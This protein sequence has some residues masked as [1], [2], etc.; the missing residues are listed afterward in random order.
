MIFQN[1]KWFKLY[2]DKQAS[3]MT[4]KTNLICNW[5]YDSIYTYNLKI[6]KGYNIEISLIFSQ[7]ITRHI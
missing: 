1:K 2:F 7:Q 3:K 5:H 6:I 4:C